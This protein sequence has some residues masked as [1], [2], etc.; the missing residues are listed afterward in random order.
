MDTLVV[1]YVDVA[2]VAP[3]PT[4]SEEPDYTT[5]IRS[6]LTK[7]KTITLFS[8]SDVPMDATPAPAVSITGYLSAT[9]PTELI[10]LPTESDE[11]WYTVQTSIPPMV[12]S[13]S[14]YEFPTLTPPVLN[15]TATGIFFSASIANSSLVQPTPF[16]PNTSSTQS[17]YAIPTLNV[18]NRAAE[19]HDNT[20]GA[21]GR[22]GVSVA[23]FS[24][25]AAAVA[26][27]V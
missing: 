19:S 5:T 12:T 14:G 27:S 9:I 4:P 24:F 26:F 6:T 15:G 7:Y 10:P 21:A 13:T 16:F 25:I 8:S 20:K 2:R 17:H 1:L 22:L 23:A 18:E 11:P 3:A